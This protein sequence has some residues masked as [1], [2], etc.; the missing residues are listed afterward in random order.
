MSNH[1]SSVLTKFIEWSTH[2]TAF[3]NTIDLSSRYVTLQIFN[4]FKQLFD[5]TVSWKNEFSKYITLQNGLISIRNTDVVND[6]TGTGNILIGNVTLKDQSNNNVTV[7]GTPASGDGSAVKAY[8]ESNSV[9]LI[10]GSGG[11]FVNSINAFGIVPDDNINNNVDTETPSIIALENNITNL[12]WNSK[13][14]E[15]TTGN[16]NQVLVNSVVDFSDNTLELV[17]N[18]QPVTFKSGNTITSHLGLQAKAVSTLYP[19]L[20]TTQANNNPSDVQYSH[21]TIVLL[22][23]VKNL[24]IRTERLENHISKLHP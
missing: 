23:V 16:S 4:S 10:G 12:L 11:F 5:K 15:M 7:I 14:F 18:L 1:N 6:V 20:I 17:K 24:L 19:N 13:T 9:N 22:D 8:G 3:L 21:V 2:Q